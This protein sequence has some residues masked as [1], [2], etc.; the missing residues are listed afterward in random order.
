MCLCMRAGAC[1]CASVCVCVWVG[2]WVWVCAHAF[3]RVCVGGKIAY[4]NTVFF[5]AGCFNPSMKCTR[6]GLKPVLNWA[7]VSSRT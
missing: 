5:D 3:I 1:V 2:G 4:V 7:N 6:L